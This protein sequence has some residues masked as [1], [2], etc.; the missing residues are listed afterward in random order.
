SSADPSDF[1]VAP[2]GS[3]S[4]ATPL[5]AGESCTV[6]VRFNPV[7]TGAR[8]G[9]LS[10]WVN[11]PSGRINAA[12][13]GDAT[14]A[15]QPVLTPDA[16]DFGS[17]QVGSVS[18]IADVTLSNSGGGPLSF[19]R[20]GIASSSANPG[21]FWVAPGGTCSTSTPLAA[22]ESCT[23]RIRFN[24]AGVG[25]RSGFLSFWVNTPAGR[26]DAV[27][28]GWVDDPCAEGCF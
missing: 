25:F 24:P 6:R 26:I 22:G 11:T 23:V 10:F 16:V 19:W 17:V 2:G 9:L 28:S 20:F 12:L 21:D 14:P 1:W 3:C 4:T 13:A 5:A 27:L 15:P 8:S 7:A 18:S